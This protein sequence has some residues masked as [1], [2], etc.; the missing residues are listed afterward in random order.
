MIDAL[1]TTLKNLLESELHT[2]IGSDISVNFATPDDQF[3]TSVSAPVVNLFL[4]DIRENN[5]LRSNEWSQ[6]RSNNKV[7][8]IPDPKRVDCSYLV[9]AWSPAD[10]RSRSQ[11]EHMFLGHVIKVLLRYPTIPK[12]YLQGSL[13]DQELP[14]P[15]T[16]L[17][18]GRLQSLGEFWQALGGKPKAAFDY[19]VTIAIQPYDIESLPYTGV[20][21]KMQLSMADNAD[22]EST[23][24]KYKDNNNT[25]VRHS[26][27]M[28]KYEVR[29]T[30]SQKD[31]KD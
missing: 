19:T 2:S 16:T 17:Q 6:E 26:H 4:Y 31:S 9:T 27:E 7:R 1:D 10:Q 20:V 25:K 15:T 23:L 14:L 11:Q 5:E 8:R 3:P 12:E 13:D 29:F 21:K 18:P 24:E 22:E 28:E 30:K